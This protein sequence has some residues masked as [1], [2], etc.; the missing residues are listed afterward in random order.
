MN[1]K[2]VQKRCCIERPKDTSTFTKDNRE[3][4]P[5]VAKRPR[6]WHWD[7]A[8]PKQWSQRRESNRPNKLVSKPLLPLRTKE[9]FHKAKLSTEP[10]KPTI[11]STVTTL[12]SSWHQ[13]GGRDHGFTPSRA[14]GDAGELHTPRTRDISKREGE[15]QD[16]SKENKRKGKK[17]RLR[18]RR[19]RSKTKQ[20]FGGW[21]E[22]LEEREK[23]V[24][25]LQLH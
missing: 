4:L 7:A 17:E 6:R 20:R 22:R 9:L 24:Q 19:H 18:H 12:D 3:L 2:R 5:T 15:R 14:G 23:L 13:N 10:Y 16:N 8:T 21:R 11:D 25:L 1:K